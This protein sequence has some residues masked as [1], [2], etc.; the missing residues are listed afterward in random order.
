VNLD[1]PI[2]SPL[3]GTAVG[4]RV[5]HARAEAEWPSYNRTLP[6]GQV[7]LVRPLACDRSRAVNLVGSI[8]VLMAKFRINTRPRIA[9][10]DLAEVREALW[11][12]RNLGILLGGF[13]CEWGRQ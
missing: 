8:D 12:C 4:E 13:I 3:C 1:Q 11:L 10:P 6:F 7:F 2:H 9:P 5:S